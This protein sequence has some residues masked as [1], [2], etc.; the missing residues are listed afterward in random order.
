MDG[1]MSTNEEEG[2]VENVVEQYFAEMDPSQQLEVFYSK[3]L[4][5]MCCLLVGKDDESA[6]AYVLK[7]QKDRACKFLLES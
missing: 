3:S 2:R 4:S 1:E 5:E 6:A 7:Y